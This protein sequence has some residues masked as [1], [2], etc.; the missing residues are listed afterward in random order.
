M[1]TSVCVVIANII[2]KADR[3]DRVGPPKSIPLR[4]TSVVDMF[5]S[6]KTHIYINNILYYIII[7]LYFYNKR[8]YNIIINH[9]II[10]IVNMI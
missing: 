3:V 6:H 2:D 10:S 8:F 7:L 5:I 4:S 9:H 1:L